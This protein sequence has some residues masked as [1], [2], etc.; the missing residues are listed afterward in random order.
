MKIVMD[1]GELEGLSA[2]EAGYPRLR[3][4]RM[5]MRL[6]NRWIRTASETDRAA[7]SALLNQILSLASTIYGT[8]YVRPDESRCNEMLDSEPGQS[9]QFITALR[10]LLENRFIRGAENATRL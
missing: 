2:E 1:T 10:G 6:V 8:D 5:L 7:R 4:L 9:L 3:S